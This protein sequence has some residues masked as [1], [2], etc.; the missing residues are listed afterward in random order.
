MKEF[1]KNKSI[2]SEDRI[3]R[4]FLSSLF[5][6]LILLMGCS[7][8][9]TMEMVENITPQLNENGDVSTE[10]V[11]EQ[12]KEEIPSNKVFVHICG[13]VNKPGVYELEEG[14]RVIDGINMAGGVNEEACPDAVN[15]AKEVSD[16]E[17]VYIPTKKEASDGVFE[18]S[19]VELSLKGASKININTANEAK[20]CEITGIGA[21]RAK[22]IIQY[23]EG[24]GGFKSVEELKN[25]TGIGEKTFE[26]IKEEITVG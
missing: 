15:L 23:R 5:A 7:N 16:G 9:V 20:L 1:N 14:S 3:I 19:N 21:T 18:T 4:L 25:V 12:I 8:D 26:K 2:K 6:C 17:K 22:A 10:V 11:T 24:H 13:A